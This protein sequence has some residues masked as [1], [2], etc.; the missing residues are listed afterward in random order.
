MR[1]TVTG[2]TGTIGSSLVDAL[3]R[4]RVERMRESR[5]SRLAASVQR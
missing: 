2:A 1:V 4:L 3:T 5:I